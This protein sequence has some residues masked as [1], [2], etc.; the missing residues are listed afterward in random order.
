[1]RMHIPTGKCCLR[2]GGMVMVAATLE[3]S[4]AA[5]GSVLWII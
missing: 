2:W 3:G 4:A 5:L 1:M